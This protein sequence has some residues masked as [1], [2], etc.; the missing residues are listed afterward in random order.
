MPLVPPDATGVIESLLPMDTAS[1]TGAFKSG[2]LFN[3][4]GLT[5]YYKRS[6]GTAAVAVTLVDISTFGTYVSG[7][8]KEVDATHMPGYYE[9][10][11]PNAALAS[12]ATW[13]DFYFQGA[14]GMAPVVLRMDIGL[15]NANV[16]SISNNAITSSSI[17]SGALNGKG[18]WL[19]TLGTNAPSGWINAA[20]IGAA[21]L[22]GKGDWLTTLG[23]NAPSGW[24]N[25]AAIGASALNGKGDWLTTLGTNAPTGWI[26]AAAI[27]SAAL[28]GKGDWLL[29][30]SYTA[31]PSVGA[32]DTQLSTTHGS[33]AWGGG[34]GLDAAGV[35]AAIGMAT[36]NLDTQ[37]AAI[38]SDTGSIVSTL[39]TLTTSVSTI[40][41]TLNAV[42][43]DVTTI[44]GQTGSIPSTSEI[45]DRFLG[46]NHE[47]GSDGGR[48]V[49]ECLQFLRN[50]WTIDVSNV[51]HVKNAAGADSWRADVTMAAG[52]PIT[53]VVPT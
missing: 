8:F 10:H 50:G 32:I 7:G 42:A 49:T 29:S 21:A 13:V 12:G 15:V 1:Q 2:I 27:A 18:D 20:A 34:G 40:D 17:N 4:G 52:D 24:I 25:A 33:G 11:P 44:I 53:S 19:T 43:G 6:S 39:A 23:T 35:R 26:N 51:L 9:F 37:L 47:G 5:C 28:N 38:K 48:T 41:T 36:A 46:R 16:V 31:P 14:A 45:A 30:S 22:N 3:A